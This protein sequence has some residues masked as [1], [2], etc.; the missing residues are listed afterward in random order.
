MRA[1]ISGLIACI[2]Y[3]ESPTCVY[4]LACI[5]IPLNYRLTKDAVLFVRANRKK[6]P[7]RSLPLTSKQR[8]EVAIRRAAACCRYDDFIFYKEY[9]ECV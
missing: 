9:E 3:Q 6:E 4:V 1:Q 5:C 8:T 2:V 7:S